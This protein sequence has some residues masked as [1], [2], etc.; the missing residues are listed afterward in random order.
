MDTNITE[1]N[2]INNLLLKFIVQRIPQIISISSDL[3]YRYNGKHIPPEIEITLRIELNPNDFCII[4]FDSILEKK[5]KSKIIDDLYHFLRTIYS[6][7]H[8][9]TISILFFPKV[10]V[11]KIMNI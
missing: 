3:N 10:S 9:R 11:S 4:Y 1:V 2:N 5:L 6:E 8:G 7:W